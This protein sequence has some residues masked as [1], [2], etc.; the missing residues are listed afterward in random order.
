[1]ETTTP[2]PTELYEIDAGFVYP[3]SAS[4]PWQL[5]GLAETVMESFLNVNGPPPEM[6]VHSKQNVNEYPAVLVVTAVIP[7]VGEAPRTTSV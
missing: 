1:M 3:A 7:N 2:V 5:G 4:A 6:I